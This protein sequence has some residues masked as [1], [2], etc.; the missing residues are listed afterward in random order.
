MTRSSAFHDAITQANRLHNAGQHAQAAELLTSFADQLDGDADALMLHGMAA[1][2]AGDTPLASASFAKA[3]ALSPD[4]PQI[5]NIHANA[6]AAIGQQDAALAVFD[7]LV[8]QQPAFLDGHINRAITAHEAGYHVRALQAADN[9]LRQ[10]PMQPRL[11][12]I[13]AMALRGAGRISEALGCFQNAINADPQRALTRFNHGATLMAAGL[14]AQ[15]KEAFGHA[16]NL[17][18]NDGRAHAGMAAAMVE[19]GA[20]DA[21][22]QR[23]RQLLPHQPLRAEASAAITRMIIEY[24][25]TDDP[26]GHQLAAA[27]AAGKDP[28]LW[29][30]AVAA[31]TGNNQFSAANDAAREALLHLPSHPALLA[32][33]IFSSAMMEPGPAAAAYAV[34]PM[35][36]LVSDSGVGAD[37]REALVQIAL[38]ARDAKLAAREA[39]I[40]TRQQPHHQSGWAYLA[41]AWRL[42][43]DEREFWLCDYD[44]LVMPVDLPAPPGEALGD[45]VA[46]LG[47]AL[48]PL[49]Q[50]RAAPGNQ[51]LRGGT[52]TSGALFDRIDPAVIAVRD[53]IRLAAEGA[54]ASLAQHA[55]HPF[56]SRRAPQLRFA[57]SWSVRLRSE[58]HHVNHIHAEGW[59]SSACYLHLPAVMNSSD[60]GDA[61]CIAFG[62]PPAILGLD[63]P[64]R[65]IVQPHPG[66]LALFPSYMWHGT[67]P[68]SGDDYRMTVACD[69]LPR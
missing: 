40:L 35:L 4:S 8:Q 51:S 16:I 27:R 60:A 24:G 22:L 11:L 21:A 56:L 62:A 67:V 59:M 26:F 6:L 46:R 65:R 63:L 58:G 20:I 18:Q 14:F 9:G 19:T 43:G 13:R 39:E 55:E 29:I 57:G 42:L 2:G 50:T 37:Y 31:M 44:R 69:M 23:Y 28:S 64:P 25:L 3:H 52:Q 38:K 10:F 17:G 47:Q 68:F 36:A 1:R 45:F 30:E 49:H 41:T 53:A 34:G 48:L 54:I 5:G 15:A 61:G 33:E 66:M 12:A 32:A 7:V